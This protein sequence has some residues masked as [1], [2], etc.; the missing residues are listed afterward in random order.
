MGKI[1]KLKN[2]IIIGAE[3]R[4][5]GKTEFACKLIN[6]F[7]SQ[8]NIIGIKV[9]TILKRDGKCPRGGEGCG[10]CSSL[11]GNYEITE[12]KDLSLKKDTSRLLRAGAEKVFW[13][14]VMKSNLHEG[15]SAL[16]KMINSESIL[17]CESNSLRHIVEPGLFLM[18][19]VKNSDNCKES[20]NEVKMFADQIID[21]DGS[22]YN[23]DINH[24][25]IFNGKWMIN[26]GLI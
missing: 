2:M 25:N 10:V 3:G 1:I 26:A 17:V 6:K 4:N 7:K 22:N 13:L 9:T 18:A 23:F 14:R 11:K 21:F 20:A 12:E 19:R 15:F 16:L 8:H 24:I 5:A